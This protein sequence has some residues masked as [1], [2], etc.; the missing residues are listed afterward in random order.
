MKDL[1]V[2]SR[3]VWTL[4]IYGNSK[5]TNYLSKCVQFTVYIYE[6]HVTGK[7]AN[8]QAGKHS[9]V[10]G[11]RMDLDGMRFCMCDGCGLCVSFLFFF[12]L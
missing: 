5:P 6:S 9:T 4:S 12:L 11:I 2:Y 3:S 10:Y 1:P 8:G 7:W